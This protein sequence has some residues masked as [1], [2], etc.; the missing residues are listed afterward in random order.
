MKFT[1]LHTHSHYSLLDGL[2]KIDD[3]IHRA[4]ELGMDSL[5]LTDH[6]VMYGALELY[7]KAQKAGIKPVIGVEAY[8]A[9]K[10]R[11]DKTPSLDNKRNHLI[12]LAK[13]ETG[14]KNLVKLTT[15]AHLEGF[16]YKPR[17]DKELLREHSE[18]LIA[19]S[20][21]IAGEVSQAILQKDMKKA[22]QVIHEFQEI[23]GKEN[24]YL[25]LED[26]PTL[27][28]QT[29]INNALIELGKTTGAPV[30]A[31][32]DI[33][34]VMKEDDKIQDILLCIQMNKTVQ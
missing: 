13:N 26:H 15:K 10:S 25:E 17:M 14:Y 34:Y 33:H 3:L 30:V 12:L 32:N 7:Q 16:Y 19:T 18:G 23:F 1:H 21:C 27:E 2:A 29:M 20:A 6:G 11:F 28:G 9:S 4:Q 22:E 31:A 5:A 8:V 24:Y